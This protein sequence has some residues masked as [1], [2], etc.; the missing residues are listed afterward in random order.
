MKA[1]GYNVIALH[2]VRIMNIELGS[3]PEGKYRSISEE[4]VKELIAE[5]SENGR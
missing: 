4:E 3:L 1:L 2:R 5:L